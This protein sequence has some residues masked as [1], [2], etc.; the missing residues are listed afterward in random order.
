MGRLIIC[1]IP[2][3][4]EESTIAEVVEGVKRH[5]DRVMVIDDGSTDGTSRIA[6]L[7]GAEVVRHPFRIGAGGAISTG[8][9]AAVRMGA[10]A[11]LTIDGDGQH[12]PDEAPRLLR[13]ISSGEADLVIGSRFL[14]DPSPMPIHKRIG[15]RAISALTSIASGLRIT[16][17][18]SGYRAYSRAVAEIVKHSSFGYGW[19]SESII[20][21]ARGGFRVLE[22]PIRTIYHPKRRRGVGMIDGTKI[23][24]DTLKRVP[25]KTRKADGL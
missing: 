2:S 23:A 9:K 12:A 10:D 21:A 14:G 22:V 11:I 5:C 19:A 16:D 1:V 4:N 20:L 18:Q 25:M 15:N 13:P 17:S 7:H 6:Q 24:Y 8:L 3:F